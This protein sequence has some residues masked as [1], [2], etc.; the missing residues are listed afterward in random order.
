M[1]YFNKILNGNIP[2]N[3]FDLIKQDKIN[4]KL[5]QVYPYLQINANNAND[6]VA[7]ILYVALIKKSM[8][9]NYNNIVSSVDH[10]LKHSLRI[11]IDSN[12]NEI[13]KL[14]VSDNDI[15]ITIIINL[16]VKTFSN[17]L[18]KMITKLPLTH[19]YKDL[20]IKLIELSGLTGLSLKSINSIADKV[21]LDYEL[22]K[23]LKINTSIN[24]QQ[25][26]YNIL[27]RDTKICK[28]ISFEC[29]FTDEYINKLALT[30]ISIWE[31][32]LDTIIKS[33]KYDKIILFYAFSIDFVDQLH[34]TTKHNIPSDKPQSIENFVVKVNTTDTKSNKKKKED[35]QEIKKNINQNKVIEGMTK[36]LSDTVTNV[37]NNNSAELS[38]FIQVSNNMSFKNLNASGNII[39]SKI[40]Q[41]INIQDEINMDVTQS[42]TNK[43]KNDI[44]KELK[45][46]IKMVTTELNSDIKKLSDTGKGS[47]NVGD[48]VGGVVNAIANVAEKGI[49]TLGEVLSAS[50]GANTSDITEDEI[51][52]TLKEE[53]NL[54]KNFTY[55]KNNEIGDKMNTILNAE[56]IAKCLQEAR[57]ENL[58]EYENLR[59][60]TGSIIIS[61]IEQQIDVKRVM[62]CA[63]NQTVINEI[64][65][66]MVA[67][68]DL[69]IDELSL[70]INSDL[71]EESKARVDGDIYA[72]GVA[73]SAILESVGNAG[74]KI[75]AE[76]GKAGGTILKE[77]GV[78][79][80]N[81]GEG[82]NEAITGVATIPLAIGFIILALGVGIY[83]AFKN[84]GVEKVDGTSNVKGTEMKTYSATS[85]AVN[86]DAVIGDTTSVDGDVGDVGDAGSFNP[87][88]GDTTS[89]EPE[90]IPLV[91]NRGGKKLKL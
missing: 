33:I 70:N 50:V 26:F 8:N 6:N 22:T 13:A 90:E 59:T 65:T 12:K 82:I 43:I 76:G 24:I 20:H 35:L 1:N 53:F 21:S 77:A 25:L 49:E 74:S 78:A 60:T 2:A 11:A 44:T 39:I 67:E 86:G 84:N 69:L 54:N 38:N 68:F 52:N 5:N 16:I 62:K 83:F 41:S 73:G 18:L 45:E 10:I 9:L 57:T 64:A 14:I 42:I 19:P 72:A 88:I 30:I 4:Y 91:L 58:L 17:E 61:E 48:V 36:L 27:I 32:I 80:K 40:K 56:N 51:T 63:F 85:E 66:T 31:L 37:V 15:Q 71:D 89:I 34:Q 3:I 46:N 29:L 87:A 47:T 75:I 7:N 23:P 28:E 79:A 55:K 81:I